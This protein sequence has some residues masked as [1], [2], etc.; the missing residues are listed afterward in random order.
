LLLADDS[1][2]IQR[3]IELTFA[4]EDVHVVA[5]SDGDSAIA[6]LD[7]EP[8]DIVL[9][10]IGMP[11]TSGYD[12]AAYIKHSPRLAH[13]PVLLLTGAFE[14][15]DQVKAT[16]AGCA[17]VLTKP[18]EPHLVIDRVRQLLQQARGD[19]AAARPTLVLPQPDRLSEQGWPPPTGTD[20]PAASSSE[21]DDF[22]DQLDAAFARLPSDRQSS[23]T[24]DTDL[25][26]RY[27]SPP[28]DLDTLEIAP[29]SQ[30]APVVEQS[31]TPPVETPRRP[32]ASPGL[33]DAFAALLAAEERGG[34]ANGIPAWAPAPQ[35]A[36]DELVERVAAVV[37]ERLSEQTVRD[38]VADRVSAIAERLVR[39]EIE[40]IKAA[41][42]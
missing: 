16:E 15:V 21:V 22:F 2:T 7:R 23:P 26:I 30:V 8:P 20:K 13:I 34:D 3:V 25:T 31:T 40:R 5:V 36:T 9:A 10:D 1:V 6:R 39:D 18:F 37:L 11:G 42:K 24:V 33:A 14:P 27:A 17:G 35:I 4:D 38:A 41:I 28:S 32:D 19:G 12:V 29:P